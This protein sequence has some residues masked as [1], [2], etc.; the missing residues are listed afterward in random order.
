MLAIWFIF[1][2]LILTYISYPLT[3]IYLTYN[4]DKYSTYDDKKKNYIKKNFIK[5]YVLYYLS[6]STIP[7]LPFI[8][9][10]IGDLNLLI[11][12]IGTLYTSG[13]TIALFKNMKLSTTTR[14]HHCITTF[15]SFI[16]L[17]IDWKCAGVL[18]K[19]LGLY[20]VLSCYSYN[21]NK[22]LALRFLEND[23]VQ[24][25][26]KKDAL[27]VYFFSCFLNWSIHAIAFLNYINNMTI[28]MGFYFLLVLVIAYDDIVLLNWLQN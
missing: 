2:N 4:Y 16:N 28:A 3:D 21:V 27:I 23:D 25:K 6:I 15:L 19:L 13:D 8:F 10:N 7:L 12:Y 20:C 5:S 24:V 26:M 14:C 18:P 17:F 22:C 1:I 9:L 11:W